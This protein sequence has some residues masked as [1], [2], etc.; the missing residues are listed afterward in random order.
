MA[1]RSIWSLQ[2][3]VFPDKGLE[4]TVLVLSIS[5]SFF[6]ESSSPHPTWS[7]HSLFL[8]LS[9]FLSDFFCPFFDLPV[10]RGARF[11]LGLIRTRK[12]F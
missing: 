9:L 4:W 8:F 6:L 5:G 10:E 2:L 11:Q 12:P 1:T 3:C 7:I